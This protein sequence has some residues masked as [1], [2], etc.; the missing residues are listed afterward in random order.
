MH[1]KQFQIELTQHGSPISPRSKLITEAQ[2][3]PTWK[4]VRYIHQQHNGEAS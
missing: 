3:E 4:T 1:R 2:R